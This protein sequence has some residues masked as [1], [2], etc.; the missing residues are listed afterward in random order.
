MKKCRLIIT[1]DC[2]KSCPSCC[3]KY[4]TIM[5]SAIDIYNIKD[6]PLG[7]DEILITGGEPLLD[8]DKTLSILKEIDEIKYSKTKVYIYTAVWNNK[9]KRLVKYISGVQYSLHSFD[10]NEKRDF[11][12]FQEY[13]KKQNISKRLYVDRAIKNY[14][15]IIPNAWDSIKIENWKTEEQ[16]LSITNSGLP[17]EEQLYILH[18]GG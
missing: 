6:I 4:S 5:N 10:K 11:N 2:N 1:F 9:F 15:K 8:I 18:E 12:Y 3:N 13:I 16:L 14:I 7:V 17:Y